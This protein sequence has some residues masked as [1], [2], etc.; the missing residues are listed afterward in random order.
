ME[1]QTE[2]PDKEGFTEVPSRGRQRKQNP[3]IGREGVVDNVPRVDTVHSQGEELN[4]G[5]TEVGTASLDNQNNESTIAAQQE[6][7]RVQESQ[8]TPPSVNS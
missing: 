5:E 3:S 7:S 8:F 6:T 2:S 4:N 1:V